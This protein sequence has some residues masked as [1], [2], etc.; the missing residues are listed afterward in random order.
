MYTKLKEIKSWNHD[1]RILYYMSFVT[2]KMLFIFYWLQGREMHTFKKL[3]QKVLMFAKA[4][5]YIYT[6]KSV[7]ESVSI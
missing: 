1:H 7:N 4:A 5:S 6:K 3:F 2:V